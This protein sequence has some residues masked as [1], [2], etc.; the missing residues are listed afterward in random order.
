[1]WFSNNVQGKH[2][3]S[4]QIVAS[5]TPSILQRAMIPKLRGV[6]RKNRACCWAPSG[7]LELTARG[8][9]SPSEDWHQAASSHPQQF[10]ITS[11]GQWQGE[12]S[13]CTHKLN[14]FYEPATCWKVNPIHTWVPFC[15]SRN[16]P[17]AHGSTWCWCWLR[18]AYIPADFP[19]T[20][21]S[22]EL[23]SNSHS[24]TIFWM[25]THQVLQPVCFNWFLKGCYIY[26]WEGHDLSISKSHREYMY[27]KT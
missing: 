4:P 1:M 14:H 17:L 5:K 7:Q 18:Y 19:S 25:N 20:L 27:V 24:T 23:E 11:G 3:K 6:T 9:T 15:S 26:Q 16:C 12:V 2:E 13:T 8:S 10:V 22:P 21:Q